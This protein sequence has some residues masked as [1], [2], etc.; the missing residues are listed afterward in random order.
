M[1]RVLLSIL[2]VAIST[3]CSSPSTSRDS[4]AGTAIAEESEVIGA[5]E[6]PTE[7]EPEEVLLVEVEQF[8][9]QPEL[10]LRGEEAIIMVAEDPGAWGEVITRLAVVPDD[11]LELLH[12]VSTALGADAKDRE[13]RIARFGGHFLLSPATETGQPSN[14]TEGYIVEIRTGKVRTFNLW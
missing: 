4:E 8:P 3:A 11:G 10:T 9:G 12:I 7:A 14:F 6:V 5:D 13:L 2:S 1:Q